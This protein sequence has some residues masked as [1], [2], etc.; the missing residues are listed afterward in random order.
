MA[1]L[2]YKIGQWAS[3]NSW[4]VIGA[5]IAILVLAAG[6]FLAFGGKLS[7]NFDVP[8]T[9]SAEVID[10]LAEELPQ[11]S[12]AA[13]TVVAHTT[14]GEAFT[15]TQQADLQK[16]IVKART[17][18]TGIEDVIDP[19][20]TEAQRGGAEQQMTD[21][22]AQLDNGQ[23]Q[24]DAGQ[25][26]LA[27]GLAQLEAGQT[28]LSE[29][30]TQLE[31]GIAQLEAA[32]DLAPAGQLDAL[33]AQLAELDAQQAAIDGQR[34][35]LE[36]GQRELEENQQ[37]IDDGRVQL[38]DGAELLGF[39]QGI[40]MVNAEDGVALINVAFTAPRMELQDEDRNGAIEFFDTN[41][42]DGVTFEYS[43]ELSQGIPPLFGPS[44][45][46]G[47]LIAAIVLIV[48]LGSVLS[49]SLPLITAVTGVGVGVAGSLAL[50][51]TI[52]MASITPILG[53]MLGLAVGIDYSLFIINRH[54]K[55]LAQ[56]MS[57]TD[58][59]GL[60]NGT[61]GNAVVF[62]GATVAIALAALDISGV[63][64]LG[65][66]GTVGAICVV[67]AVLVAVTMTPAL[68]GLVGERVLKDKARERMTAKAQTVTAKPMSTPVAIATIVAPGAVLLTIA[69]PA[70]QMRLG[71]PD[72]SSDPHES[73]SYQAYTIMADSF[74][75]GAN[76]NLLATVN[77]EPGL[78][79]QEQ[80]PFQLEVARAI[81][82]HEAV[83]AV[84][85]VGVSD[86][87][88]AV[89]QIKPTEG[90]NAESTAD[91]VHDLRNSA[92]LAGT[93]LET[94][95]L[96]V[97]GAAAMAIDAS[98]ILADALPLYLA[99]V[100]GL[101]LIILIVVFRSLLVPIVATAGFALSL[102]ATYGAT[103]A[104]FQFGWL[105]S[106]FNV[107]APGPIL[108]F[109]PIILVG[110]LFGLAMDYQL[111]LASGMRE[112]Y[113]HGAPAK[114][115]VAQGLRA[116]RAVVIAAALIMISVFG[117]FVFTEF[118][119]IRS[120]GFGLAVG[121]LFDAFIV[122]LLLMPAVMHLLGKSAWWL[123][124]WLDKI[125]PNVDVEGAAL[126]RK[127]ELVH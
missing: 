12:G 122:R 119:L 49:A 75:E 90:P 40:R 86:S 62:A 113:V 2:L 17:E 115:A 84:V 51:G 22:E 82:Q 110:V 39:S 23:A 11:F 35:Q 72:G 76:A 34:A 99:V 123:P 93:S 125:L 96:K 77:V 94:Q 105:G 95:D 63:S 46:I 3:R 124:K 55:Q 80:I 104:V 102:F 21:A 25:Q 52:A 50:S 116:S 45:A 112:A 41:P 92:T 114:L 81:S 69:A 14:N 38:A 109:L 101:S 126:E 121:V 87:G 106:I 37:A 73:T 24:L 68:L 118:A 28:Q 54:R 97:A 74:G 27:D 36:T 57:V 10:Q 61:A 47:L 1:E 64:F 13:G 89:F 20:E 19:F 111:F 67:I 60:A 42:V 120:I 100:I 18:L 78:S 103:T 5:W 65:V 91:L 8:G 33:R 26:Q 15:E 30:R 66:M 4:R 29:G 117:G 53:L 107:S 83:E 32:G 71:L 56:G 6:A 31:A 58:S 85:P 127:H 88:L 79:E 70:L 48:M 59:I 98:Q 108:A 16:L 44:E 7:N 43:S 9:K